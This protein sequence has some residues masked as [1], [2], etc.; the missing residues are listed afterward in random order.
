MTVI[1]QYRKLKVDS[2]GDL[3]WNFLFSEA[4]TFFEICNSQERKMIFKFCF[5]Y[6]KDR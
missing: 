5:C 3:F 2:K 6:L 4:F 1:L